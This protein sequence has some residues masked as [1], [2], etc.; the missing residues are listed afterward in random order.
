MR[1]PAAF[2]PTARRAGL[3]PAL[4][5]LVL[6]RAVAEAERLHARG[7][8]WHIAVNIAPP[9]LLSGFVLPRLEGLARAANLPVGALVVEV[10]EDSFLTEPERAKELLAE[11]HGKGVEISVDDFGTGF[12]SLAY[13]RDLQA[14]EVKIDQSF[15]STMMTQ[16][17]CFMIVDS[18]T[19]MAHG[20]GLRVVAEGVETDDTAAALVGLG[21]DTLQGYL[22][23]R[24]MPPA[25]LDVW[26]A[27]YGQE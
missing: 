3:M 6:R 24:P 10:T 9:E 19:R 20:L 11:L 21:V 18:T 23:A 26:A 17:K 14:Q 27:A 8:H 15:V 4:T 13:L 12:S 22:I 5:E 25:D 16:E 1:S 2:L 7:R